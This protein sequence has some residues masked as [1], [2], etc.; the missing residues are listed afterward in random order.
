M[1]IEQ[2]MTDSLTNSLTNSLTRLENSFFDFKERQEKRWNNFYMPANTPINYRPSKFHI[3]HDQDIN[4]THYL[5]SGQLSHKAMQ[6]SDGSGAFLIPNPISEMI[7][8]DMENI[9]PLRLLCSLATISGNTF[10]IILDNTDAEVGWVNEKGGRDETVSPELR[11]L[12]IHIHELYAKPKISQ[13]LLDDSF[14]DLSTWIIKKISEQ[15]G[16]KKTN[17]SCLDTKTVSHKGY[18]L[19]KQRKK[20]L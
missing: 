2:K 11:K 9:C 18:Y 16:K 10:E 14:L 20:E 8:K 3:P 5:K 7:Q 17:L 13:Q 6:S 4:F 12:N 19:L 1:N 15:M